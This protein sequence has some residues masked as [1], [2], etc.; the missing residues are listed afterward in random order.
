MHILISG[1]SRFYQ[2][3]GICR[4]S[5][6]LAW[7]LS[8][9]DIVSKITLLVGAWQR[10]YFL[11]CFNLSSPKI[12]VVP[13][14]MQNNSL[15][16]NLW[17]AFQLP[18]IANAYEVNLV[19]VSF[20]VPVSRTLFRMP[21]VTTVHDM[22]PY[23][24]PATFGSLNAFFKRLF[25]HQCVR[26]SDA[27]ACV[28]Q[29]TMES[30]RRYEK[31]VGKKKIVRVVPN[32]ADFSDDRMEVPEALRG[33]LQPFILAVGQHQWNKR[34]DLLIDAFHRLRKDDKLTGDLQ[35]VIAGSPGSQTERLLKQVKRLQLSEQVHWLPAV[36]DAELVWLYQNCELFVASS[37]IEGFCIPLLEALYFSCR[38]VCTDLP[39]L[40]E[41]AGD[42]P[43]FFDISRT[44]VENLAAAIVRGL[45]APKNTS[46]SRLCF[47]G[48]TTAAECLS[49]YSLLLP[50][51][52]AEVGGVD[53]LQPS[54]IARG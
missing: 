15:M 8:E 27:L 29:T 50:E 26:T 2:P 11:D 35:L 16:R 18:R 46:S 53:L 24:F 10:D 37:A 21:L 17:F 49:L 54:A 38:A 47:S 39:V 32:Y 25:F 4:H 7:C 42:N 41:I 34:F 43:V 13:V 22:Y 51:L 45:D 3:T 30:L 28:S 48:E 40:R 9:T 44:P 52:A 20:P 19:H 12:Q 5:A 14:H 36:T 1:L 31:T 6:N 23:E 33:S